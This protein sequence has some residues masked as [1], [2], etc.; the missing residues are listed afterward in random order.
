LLPPPA[1]TPL[2][3][4]RIEVLYPGGTRKDG[5]LDITRT[6]IVGRRADS[7]LVLNDDTVSGQH[8]ELIA[9]EGSLLVRD[10]QSENGTFIDGERVR[11]GRVR[12][13][14][15]VRVG[16]TELKIGEIAG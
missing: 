6:A 13:G 7:D 15:V 3:T 4:V 2:R 14:D 1:G 11:Q 5:V 16:D 9:G 10:L 8:A 12:P